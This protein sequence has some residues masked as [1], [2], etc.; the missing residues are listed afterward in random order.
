MVVDAVYLAV[1]SAVRVL[2]ADSGVDAHHIDEIVYVGGTTCSPGL[3]DC[4]C[5]SGGFR[6]RKEIES[7]F[8]RGT[9]A[10]GLRRRH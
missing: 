4:I 1:Y 10:G 6:V 8:L 7:P 3:D 2:L 5:L 9:V